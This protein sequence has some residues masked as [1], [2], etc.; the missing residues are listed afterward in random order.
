VGRA[1]K[2]ANPNIANPGW[3]SD[4]GVGLRLAVDRTAFAN[5]L[6]IDLAVPFKQGPGIEQVEIVVRSKLTF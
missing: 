2:G 5:V 4:A 6:H 1:W 3:L